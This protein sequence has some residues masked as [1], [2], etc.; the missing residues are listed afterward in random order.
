MSSPLHWPAFLPSPQSKVSCTSR[1]PVT[2][3]VGA[4]VRVP[5]P[6]AALSVF[7]EAARMAVNVN[8]LVNILNLHRKWESG[9]FLWLACS[10]G[11][12]AGSSAA[13]TGGIH[14]VH[15]LNAILKYLT[16][17]QIQH[18]LPCRR[19]RICWQTFKVAPRGPEAG[20]SVWSRCYWF[21][22]SQPSMLSNF[23]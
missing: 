19:T 4:T 17:L 21:S 2:L 1:W 13:V 12:T 11:L 20:A 16:I 7:A 23:S 10:K 6:I 15:Y 18:K 8:Q 3:T 22:I 14:P 9:V 5:R